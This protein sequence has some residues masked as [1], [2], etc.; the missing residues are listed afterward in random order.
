MSIRYKFILFFVALH[1][2]AAASAYVYELI[3]Q[4]EKYI[5]T[6][7]DK[8]Y[9]NRKAQYENFIEEEKT[10]LNALAEELS[11]NKRVVAAY[12]KDDRTI[13]I[14]QFESFWKHMADNALINEIH[15]F[16]KPAL[17]FV[18]FANV[19]A[20]NIDASAV[21]GDIGWVTSTFQPSSHFLV[22]RLYPGLRATYPIIHDD[23]MLG[24]VSLGVD[25]DKLAH[26]MQKLFNSQV[27]FAL[28][29]QALQQNLKPDRYASIAGQGTLK[30]EYR[31]FGDTKDVSERFLKQEKIFRNGISY[32]VFPILDFHEE[33]IGYFIFKDD[34][35]EKIAFFEAQAWKTFAYYTM[36]G[37]LV[38]VAI[39]LLINRI[40]KTLDHL[41][42]IL[43]AIRDKDFDKLNLIKREAS[44]RQCDEICRFE[45]QLVATGFEIK[46]YFDLLTKE[47]H[48][49]ADK[50]HMD[51]LTHV[52]NRHAIDD[53]G[54]NLFLKSQLAK[55]SMSVMMLDIDDF[56]SIN[57]TYGHDFG[58]IVLKHI[59]ENVQKQLRSDDFLA[60]YG[61]EEFVILLPKTAI[62][63]GFEI[64]QKICRRIQSDETVI[65]SKSVKVTVSIGLT[66]IH[67]EDGTLYDT[68]K[69]ADTKLYVAKQNGK[70]RVEV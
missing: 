48:D 68:I 4:K 58:D 1:M 31:F 39:L 32:A 33:K 21:R 28:K 37:V 43:H 29:E 62:E 24:G 15:F 22:C 51:A 46:N 54:E 53:I 9:V 8:M 3:Y 7:I 47:M 36:I 23:T 10:R 16:K 41:T 60:R 64:A 61:G 18:N 26:S 11:Q 49:Y 52:F 50:M 69:R 34:F 44:E 13:I 20:Y 67:E 57:D 63:Q 66:E 2:F 5:T 19:D 12:E 6:S 70:N 45:R 35:S 14:D 27:L 59:S 65:G 17:S 55:Q 56:K 40:V 25:M 30:N 38:F 42:G